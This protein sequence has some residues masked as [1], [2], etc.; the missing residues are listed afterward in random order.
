MKNLLTFVVL[1]LAVCGLLW[2]VAGSG[3]GLWKP[4]EPVKGLV[5]FEVDGGSQARWVMGSPD[6]GRT[7]AASMPG[8]TP[9]PEAPLGKLGPSERGATEGVAELPQPVEGIDTGIVI[10]HDLISSSFDLSEEEMNGHAWRASAVSGQHVLDQAF[11]LRTFEERIKRLTSSD[12]E[13]A[14]AVLDPLRS[15]MN[16]LRDEANALMVDASKDWYLGGKYP[17]QLRSLG[18]PIPR[19][20]GESLFVTDSIVGLGGY[21]ADLGFRSADYPELN[22]RLIQGSDLKGLISVQLAP[23]FAQ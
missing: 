13:R 4:S 11:S 17:H 6:Q 23:F 2:G 8:A 15:E 10:A 3:D 18:I 20:H 9:P 7:E 22:A 5:P 16:D 19:P 21:Y 14:E 12:S 1:G